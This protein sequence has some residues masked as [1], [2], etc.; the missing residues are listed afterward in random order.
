MNAMEAPMTLTKQ[1]YFFL[2]LLVVAAVALT[3]GI[4]ALVFH[5]G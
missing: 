2:L 3:D 5:V 1:T 4:A